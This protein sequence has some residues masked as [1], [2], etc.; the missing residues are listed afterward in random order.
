MIVDQ[1]APPGS[2]QAKDPNAVA[3]PGHSLTQD[4]ERWPWGKPPQVTD[5][6]VAFD[7]A[8]NSL[9]QPRVRKEMMK[10][11]IVGAS[12]EALVEGYI[13][14][15]FHEGRFMPD[16]GMLIKPMLA[17][18]IANEA[19]EED[20]PYRF[21]ENENQLEEGEMDDQTF[22]RMMKQNNPRMFT[23]V[24]DKINKSIRRGFSE[25]EQQNFMGMTAD[26]EETQ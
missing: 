9:E 20:I 7:E 25:E 1:P 18:Y 11:L 8:V 4:N 17:L 26:M 16:V 19:E 24:S 12:V 22:F 2:I 14:Q 5:P 10:L 3:P 6:S 21:F 15:A 23:F 13:L